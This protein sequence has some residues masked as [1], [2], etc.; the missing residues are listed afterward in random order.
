MEDDV[1]EIIDKSQKK[2]GFI[3]S[4]L[5]DLAEYSPETLIAYNYLESN[6]KSM[7]L[8]P[9]EKQVVM[10]RISEKNSSSTCIDYHSELLE[11]YRSD[12]KWQT[13]SDLK[14]VDQLIVMTDKITDQSGQITFE[15]I[16]NFEKVGFEKKQIF[17]IVHLI[18][19]KTISNLSTNIS[20]E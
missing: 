1:E 10:L 13:E 8:T 14:K 6:L 5:V 19:L 15:E 3:P 18:V 20:L 2:L 9:F 7:E 11:I 17:D 12:L 4:Y 16:Q